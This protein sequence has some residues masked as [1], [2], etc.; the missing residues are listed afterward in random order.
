MSTNHGHQFATTD[1]EEQ[2]ALELAIAASIHDTGNFG[3]ETRGHPMS[4]GSF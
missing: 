1:V 3:L 2:L 4:N